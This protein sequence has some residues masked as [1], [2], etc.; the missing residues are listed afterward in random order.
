MLRDPVGPRAPK[1]PSF[2]SNFRDWWKLRSDPNNTA[3]AERLWSLLLVVFFPVV[4]IGGNF[5]AGSVS[6]HYGGVGWRFLTCSG[7][8]LAEGGQGPWDGRRWVSSVCLG[9][10]VLRGGLAGVPLSECLQG[11]AGWAGVARFSDAYSLE[12]REA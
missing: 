6:S 3:K 9:A 5:R 8:Y 4:V 7:M 10:C 1:Q 11:R 12:W 2:T